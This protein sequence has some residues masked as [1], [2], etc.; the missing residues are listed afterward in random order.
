[1]SHACNLS[2]LGGKRSKFEANPANSLQDPISKTPITKR[3]GRV[4]Q[5]EGPELKSY[6]YNKKRIWN[7][8]FEG[9]VKGT[10]VWDQGGG[11][12]F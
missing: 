7:W 2:Y 12:V 3:V 6:Y 1:V 8:I 10:E 9:V 4:A 5:G 11:H